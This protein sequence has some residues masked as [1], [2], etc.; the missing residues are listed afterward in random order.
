MNFLVIAPLGLMVGVAVGTGVGRG[1]EVAVVP[2]A[3][4]SSPRN[5]K[6]PIKPL[7]RFISIPSQR[8]ADIDAMGAFDWTVSLGDYNFAD[9]GRVQDT[10]EG[11]RTRPVEL[12]SK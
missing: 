12:Q 4:A 1:V 7:L 6:R 2:Q 10:G 5:I 9:H 8:T 3:I 11:V